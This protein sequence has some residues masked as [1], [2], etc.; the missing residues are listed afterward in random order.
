M[1][2]RSRNAKCVCGE[3]KW[4]R[5]VFTPTALSLS[6]AH[7]LSLSLLQLNLLQ[8]GENDPFPMFVP[9]CCYFLQQAAI[10][11]HFVPT[12]SLNARESST[13]L[14]SARSSPN[15]CSAFTTSTKFYPILSPANLKVV[16]Q[17]VFLNSLAKPKSFLI[18]Q[19]DIL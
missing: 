8:K 7:L 9:T 16:L 15:T 19:T 14:H 5:V 6:P 13:S 3:D 18:V 4:S 12:I 11:P 17:Q 2:E 10:S 1:A